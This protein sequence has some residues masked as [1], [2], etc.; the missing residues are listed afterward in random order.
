MNEQKPETKPEPVMVG[1]VLST[2]LEIMEVSEQRKAELERLKNEVKTL[3]VLQEQAAALRAEHVARA[4]ARVIVAESLQRA[5]RNKLVVTAQCLKKLVSVLEVISDQHIPDRFTTMV[6]VA[7]REGV[8]L[9]QLLMNEN[10][11]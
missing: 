8:E 1:A 6:T 5:T 9:L 3:R 4:Q 10:V 11:L 7:R 2:Y